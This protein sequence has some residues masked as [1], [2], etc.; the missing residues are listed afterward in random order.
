MQLG[1][2]AVDPGVHGLRCVD[3]EGCRRPHPAGLTLA[4]CVVVGSI[5]D[6]D[7]EPPLVSD[8]RVPVTTGRWSAY[9][10]LEMTTTAGSRCSQ[11]LSST[12]HTRA[13]AR[14]G[15]STACVVASRVRTFASR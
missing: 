4:A 3:F 13:A 14:P 7:P 9:G 11:P 2:L 10:L 1:G 12:R 5:E 15:P 8:G 6:E